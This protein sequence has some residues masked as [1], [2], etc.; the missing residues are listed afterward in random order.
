MLVIGIGDL[1]ILE[2]PE[3]FLLIEIMICNEILEKKSIL[4]FS[5]P[6]TSDYDMPNY[7]LLLEATTDCARSG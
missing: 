1:S 5:K 6:Q 4:R 2:Y 3:K 7:P